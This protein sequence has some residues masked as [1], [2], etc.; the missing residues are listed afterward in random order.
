MPRGGTPLSPLAWGGDREV[1]LYVSVDF[2]VHFSVSYQYV[3]RF[4]SH[5]YPF[6]YAHDMHFQQRITP[7]EG[8]TA[9]SP[10]DTVSVLPY[11]VVS[12]EIARRVSLKY[13]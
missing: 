2:P 8:D 11:R 13:Q 3:S 10:R 5:V 12:A 1:S 4:V 7:P 9:L 6:L